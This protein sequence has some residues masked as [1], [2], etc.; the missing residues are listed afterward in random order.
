MFFFKKKKNCRHLD[1]TTTGDYPK[2]MRDAV[3]DRLPKFT[4]EQSAKLKGSA[5]FIGLNYY[6]SKF[7]KELESKILKNPRW[8]QDL[9][10]EWQGKF[11]IF[12]YMKP[13]QE[14]QCQQKKKII[15]EVSFVFGTNQFKYVYPFFRVQ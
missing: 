2:T 4:T 3:G 8:L 15:K 5:D 14:N 11:F 6:V 10:V 7:P 1:P 12:T 9:G 13:N